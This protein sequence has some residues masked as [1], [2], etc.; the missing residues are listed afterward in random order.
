MDWVVE[1]DLTA[2]GKRVLPWLELDPVRNSV[3]ATVLMTRLDGTVEP[4][5]V[6]TA[7]LAGPGGEIAGVALR[8][9]PRG[10]LVTALPA[11]AAGTLAAIATEGIGAAS[12][13]PPDAG[14]FCRAYAARTGA[15]PVRER[16]E[17]LYRLDV[18][19]PPP[20]VP[21]R[22]RPMAAAEVDLLVRWLREF[23]DESHAAFETG[24]DVAARSIAQGR[25]V[26][27]E[28]DGEPVCLVGFNPP[29]GRVPRIGPV[30][31]PPEHRRRGYAAAAT[32]AT[33]R[34]L[35]DGGAVA[36]ALFADDANPTAV[37][38]YTRL[39]FRPV[40]DQED[41]RLEY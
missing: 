41:W 39:G 18:L 26:L 15:R 35:L 8:T 40:A 37:G 4:V 38:V 32:A 7:W 22:L 17:Q 25:R 31:T 9:P 24:A 29:V 3:P 21:G 30:W 19:A 13:P 11:G 33:C 12:G 27:W 14:D 6:W 20:P 1:T 2:Y 5:D 10:M 34:L 36:V 16:S 28:V 23:S